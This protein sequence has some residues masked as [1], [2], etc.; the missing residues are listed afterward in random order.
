VVRLKCSNCGKT[1]DKKALVSFGSV[2]A[3]GAGLGVRYG[4]LLWPFTLRVYAKC[5]LCEQT[6]WIRVLPPWSKS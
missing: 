5:P 1:F 2:G 3:T 6:G 4:V